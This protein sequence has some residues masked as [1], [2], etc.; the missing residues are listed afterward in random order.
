VRFSKPVYESLPWLY[1]S[2]GAAALVA[3]YRLRTGA[4]ATLVSLGGLIAIIAGVAVWLRRRDSR[5][6]SAE[7][8]GE[9]PP[10]V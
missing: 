6:R 2:C 7:Y 5:A 8:G 3:G 10:A 9:E 4:A 1:S